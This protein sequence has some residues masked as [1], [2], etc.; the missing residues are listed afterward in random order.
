MTETI[1][2]RKVYTMD[3]V[4]QWMTLHLRFSLLIRGRDWKQTVRQI[5]CVCGPVY[6]SR[7]CAHLGL[8]WAAGVAAA[9]P[10]SAQL[11][12]ARLSSANKYNKERKGK[13]PSSLQEERGGW[14]CSVSA[15]QT[16][17]RF[18]ML[19]FLHCVLAVARPQSCSGPMG[20]ESS[21]IKRVELFRFGKG[22]C[23]TDWSQ[24]SPRFG[25]RPLPTGSKPHQDWRPLNLLN[26]SQV[27]NMLRYLALS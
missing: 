24:A 21:V 5:N 26:P 16:H 20:K 4:S 13:A 17:G 2:P 7:S 3:F 9:R 14:G 27:K 10:H 12:L 6:Q 22:P 1:N 11:G 15:G 18:W 25:S 23:A 8:G 19:H